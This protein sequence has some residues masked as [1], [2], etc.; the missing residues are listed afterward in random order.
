MYILEVGKSFCILIIDEY[1]GCF[2][3]ELIWRLLDSFQ[4]INE[5]FLAQG[6]LISTYSQAGVSFLFG[7]AHQLIKDLLR[8]VPVPCFFWVITGKAAP[9]E[10]TRQGAPHAVCSGN[11]S[12]KGRRS[13]PVVLPFIS[14]RNH[15]LYV[16]GPLYRG[17]HTFGRVLK[18]IKEGVNTECTM[19]LHEVVSISNLM[20][21]VTPQVWKPLI[22]K[23]YYSDSK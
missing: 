18:F 23:D 19:L 3:D 6:G 16:E 13:K 9:A 8:A 11:A 2:Q 4:H 12:I 14:G 5:M 7:N 1:S 21:N 17:I 22:R 20:L 10:D 15:I